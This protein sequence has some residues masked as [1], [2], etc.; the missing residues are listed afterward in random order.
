[1]PEKAHTIAKCCICG[2]EFEKSVANSKYCSDEC[3]KVGLSNNVK[4][5]HERKM[6]QELEQRKKRKRQKNNRDKITEIA[7]AARKEGL[8]Y[9]Q[10]VAKYM[11]RF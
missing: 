7:I 4:N 2:K 10:Y 3:R 1:M 8:T 11:G 6:Q 5:F 9:G